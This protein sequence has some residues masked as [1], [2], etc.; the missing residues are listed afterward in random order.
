MTDVRGVN[1]N[2]AEKACELMNAAAINANNASVLFFIM[3]SDFQA[4]GMLF[5]VSC[6]LEFVCWVLLVV[7]WMLHSGNCKLFGGNKIEHLLFF[8]IHLFTN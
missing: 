4:F 5:V 7:G 8:F 3:I 2:W 6:M 1:K